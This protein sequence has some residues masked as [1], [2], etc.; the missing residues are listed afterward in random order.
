M[1]NN[2]DSLSDPDYVEEFEKIT[3][4][5]LVL[6]VILSLLKGYICR[7]SK[8]DT[9]S[10]IWINCIKVAVFIKNGEKKYHFLPVD[11]STKS[12]VK[13]IV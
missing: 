10:D 1:L 11:N 2:P 5:G 3:N 9:M 13:R 7:G 8:D 12:L 4:K 6:W